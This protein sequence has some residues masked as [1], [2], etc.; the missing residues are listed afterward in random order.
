M[1]VL[2]EKALME[3]GK[4]SNLRNQAQF[5][6]SNSTNVNT[7]CWLS[8]YLVKPCFDKIQER[9]QLGWRCISKQ[10]D[11]RNWLVIYLCKYSVNGDASTHYLPKIQR[12]RKV[13][14]GE[15]V[16]IISNTPMLHCIYVIYLNLCFRRYFKV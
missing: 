10:I 4:K 2:L 14:L 7:V 3:A 15:G 11:A 16:Y 8:K 12:I 9:I 6:D 5:K 13:T 1:N